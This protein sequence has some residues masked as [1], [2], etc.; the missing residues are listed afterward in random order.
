MNIAEFAIQ[1][2]TIIYL[3]AV[4]FF[5]GGII[6][7]MNVGRLED[8]DFTIN[9]VKIVTVYPGASPYEV[10]EEVSD[11]IEQYAQKIQEVD[12]VESES[13]YGYSIV[14][15]TYDV[16][17]NSEEYRQ[18]YDELRKRISDAQLYLPRGVYPS[19]VNDDFKDVYGIMYALT[20][21]GYS[22]R[23][24]HSFSEYIQKQL[25]LVDGVAKVELMSEPTEV[26]YLELSRSKLVGMG[27]SEEDIY[28]LIQYQNKIV[29]SGTVLMGGERLQFSV[30]GNLD[31]IQ[32]LG[33]IVIASAGDRN[34]YLSDIADIYM[35]YK[36]PPS[37]IFRYNGEQAIGLGISVMTTE[38]VVEVGERI[39]ERLKELKEE[40]P[41]GLELENIFNQPNAVETSINNFL[42]SL[43]QAVVIVVALLMVFMGLQSG[44]IIGGILVLIIA[45]TLLFMYL[46]GITL[47]R[48]SLGALIIAMGMLVDNSIVV[49][50]GI[51]VRYQKGE[52]R[53]EAAKQVIKQTTW[54]LFAATIVA[55]IAF[56]SVGM[57]PDSAGEYTKTLFYVIIIS[58]MLSWVL[59]IT[60][61]PLVCYHFMRPKEISDRDHQ[62]NGKTMS[63][64]RKFLTVSLRYK[65]ISL[66]I[67][68]AILAVSITGFRYI[69]TAFFPS[70]SQPQFQIDY[71]MPEGTDIFETEKGMNL[72]EEFLMDK[73][74]Y[75]HITKVSTFVGEAPLRF[76]LTFSPEMPNGKYGMFL[77]EVDD[78]DILDEMLSQIQK[79]LN[80]KFSEPIIQLI[81]Y[82][83]GSA[84]NGTVNT[85][86]YGPD[87][88]ILRELGEEVKKIYKSTDNAVA[89]RD[90]WGE[91]IKV[92]DLQIDEFQARRVG[93]TRPQINLA[94]KQG[95]DGRTV[96]LFRSGNKQLPII[97]IPPESERNDIAFVK[98][99]YV[100][101]SLLKASIPLIQLVKE[102]GFVWK[103][104]VVSRRDR[105]R[106][107]E[108][109]CDPAEGQPSV[110][111]NQVRPAID[112]LELP[113]SYHI[114]HGGE[115]ENS[116][117]ATANVLANL[118]IAL[119]AMLLTIIL[120]WN[121]LRQPIIVFL[122]IPLSV[123]GV[124]LGLLLTNTPF[125]FMAIMGL[126]SLFGM[127]IKNA[128]VLVDE[129]DL[130]LKTEIDPFEGIIEASISRVR[131]VLMAAFSTILG[132]IPLVADSF[133]HS[134][135]VTIM[136]GLAV[137]SAITLVVI[138][139]LY[140]LF[141][142]IN[143][144]EFS[145]EVLLES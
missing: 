22:L 86:I 110:L 133:F 15:V 29:D 52:D 38:N 50:E 33:D 93:I 91:K 119:F 70:S 143:P 144:R 75:P 9:V 16:G 19:I 92:M 140:A 63:L 20:G 73:E 114:E 30:S 18:M 90:S 26:V 118:P 40:T 45:G 69:E 1:K 130:T 142:K 115:Y 102:S 141:F 129:F 43:L 56:A 77:V 24:M 134:M 67:V 137:A 121:A 112:A 57:S 64:Y 32:T 109:L 83:L 104:R 35:G 12:Y 76:Q 46:F 41:I 107:I 126:L 145:K 28:S 87:P 103:D 100:Y 116:K 94:L 111:F 37:G 95:F 101:S 4:L 5:V 49:T 123:I 53:L 127:V 120:L 6:G 84:A 61:N 132:M 2:K 85:R 82:S 131:P 51:F 74:K 97:S 27:I 124:S 34:V 62:L 68:L 99:L 25:L 135:A 21:D 48:V 36:N 125:S 59:A 54:P 139:V 7:F 72:V 108:V 136:C 3:M 81:R 8:P 78:S 96:G 71:W 89:V 80:E 79:E 106:M 10:E 113:P 14:T 66:M 65:W 98:D 39:N 117:N 44:L 88:E 17:Y 128:I 60:F 55:I 31:T 47:Q 122:S 11:I 13:T 58:L 105:S 42:I 23:E 138:P